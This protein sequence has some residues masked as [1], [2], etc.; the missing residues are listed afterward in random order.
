MLSQLYGKI[1][2]LMFIFSS[3]AVSFGQGQLLDASELQ[4][5]T[6]FTSFEK[7]NAVSTDSIYRLSFK[8]KL[9]ED[10]AQ[11]ILQYPH[12]QELH[13]TGMRLKE[14]PEVVWTLTHLTVLDL[15]NN[16]LDS[17]SYR[18]GDL[19][20]LERL[21]LNRNYLIFLPVE[22]IHLSHLSFLDLWS[23]LIITFPKEITVLGSTLKTVDMRVITI[24]DEYK[25]RLQSLLPETK[26]LFSK[27]CNCKN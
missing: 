3:S 1:T 19:I 14:V 13:L 5:K 10:F 21:I 20:H 4:N 23:N 6:L 16:R 25:E 11:Q 12:L 7:A 22:I 24:G 2:V 8:R 27:Y 9:P 17:L 15:S 18:I 26:F